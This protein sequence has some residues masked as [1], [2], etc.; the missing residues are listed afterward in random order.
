MVS[1][2]SRERGAGVWSYEGRDTQQTE[3][4]TD[5]QQERQRQKSNKRRKRRSV[6]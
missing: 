6:E 1:E 3:K 2:E 4:E 5:N